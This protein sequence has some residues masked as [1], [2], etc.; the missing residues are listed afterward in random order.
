MKKSLA[1]LL[2]L[3]L[4]CFFCFAYADDEVE[5]PEVDTS[6]EEPVDEGTV[7]EEQHVHEWENFKE[8]PATREMDGN[9]AYRMCYGCGMM[10]DEKGK[11]I[12]EIPI[13]PML[14]VEAD[15]PGADFG[16]V[17]EGYSTIKP[18]MIARLYSEDPSITD[19]YRKPTFDRKCFEESYKRYTEKNE[20]GVIAHIVEVYLRP[21]DKLPEDDYSEELSFM[22]DKDSEPIAC[23][24]TFIVEPKVEEE[25]PEMEVKDKRYRILV[26]YGHGGE[27]KPH[28]GYV[29]EGETQ[30]YEITPIVGY[31]LKDLRVDEVY[32]QNPELSYT[33]EEVKDEHKIEAIFELDPNYRPE[34]SGE[35]FEEPQI[36]IDV[37][38]EHKVFKD[39][40]END[41]FYQSVNFVVDNKL[42]NGTSDDEFTPGGNLTR[43]MLVTVLYRLSKASETE[44]AYF[45]DVD[46]N[47]YYSEPIAWA[48]SNS[49]VNGIGDNKFGPDNNITRQDL[50]TIIYRYVK[51]IITEEDPT[52]EIDLTMYNDLNLISSYALTPF[53]WALS[54]SIMSGRSENEL[55]PDGLATRAET[56]IIMERVYSLLSY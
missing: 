49:I 36:P 22:T 42:F 6:S 30:T 55:A 24:V 45:D 4:C 53:K 13:I 21:L 10:Q 5:N 35:E 31:R 7:E 37:P 14:R 15:Y 48:A 16:Q 56:A 32:V 50:I 3:L 1:V 2:V 41:W 40:N 52:Y 27:I 51:T 38:V 23:T 33:F 26:T 34:T 20:Y 9:K 19:F 47:M 28:T 54:N 17:Q 43:G 18:A 39:V 11:E 12:F 8:V 25:K 29:T 46:S 44:K